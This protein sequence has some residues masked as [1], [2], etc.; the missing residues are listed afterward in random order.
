MSSRKTTTD[1][2]PKEK[3]MSFLSL[4]ITIVAVLVC[5]W[6]LRSFVIEPYEIPSGS[7]EDT[8]E[9]QDRVFSEKI[10]LATQ[11]VTP[12]QIYTFT[13]PHNSDR[14]LIKRCIAVGGQ[15]V[16]IHDGNLYID[17][18]LQDEPYTEGKPTTELQTLP[19]VHISYPYTVPDGYM[20]MMG[21]NRT[22]SADSRYFGA[23]PVSSATGH[24][25]V[26]YW[27]LDRAGSL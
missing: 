20:W 15:T 18:V 13:D 16:D 10:S 9:I 6:F 5:V 19:G 24:A 17:G 1:S 3:H 2:T 12:G 7:M 27:P 14:T 25:F 26:R 8:I 11:G 4:V 22:N 23:V 21:D